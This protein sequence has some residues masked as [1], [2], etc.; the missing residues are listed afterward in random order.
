MMLDIRYWIFALS[1]T[2]RKL[3]KKDPIIAHRDVIGTDF[4]QILL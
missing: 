3:L 1:M 2:G 4:G